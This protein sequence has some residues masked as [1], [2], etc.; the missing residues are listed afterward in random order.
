M[1]HVI[2]FISVFAAIVHIAAAPGSAE[3]RVTANAEMG[4]LRSLYHDIQIGEDGYRFNYV[5]EG[6]QEILMPFTRFEIQTV[7]NDRTQLNFLYQPLTLNTKTRVDRAGGIKVDGLVF[8]DDTPLDLQYGFDFYRLTWRR[9]VSGEPWQLW[10]GAALQIR[11][12]SIIFDGYDAAGDQIRAMSQ[13]L[14]PVPVLS[15]A[16]RREYPQGAFLAATLEGFFAPVKYLNLRDVDVVGWLYDT[17]FLFGVPVRPDSEAYISLRFVGGGAEGT[18]SDRKYWTQSRDVPRWTWNN[19]N[20][21]IVSLG[22][23][24]HL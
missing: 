1:K 13:D 16:L 22:M 23:R 6:G 11:N 17:A 4:F 8:A 20:L 7:I 15:M 5:K 10:L 9:L 24:L 12:A 3:V 19:L 2:Q 14:G 18:G 21:A